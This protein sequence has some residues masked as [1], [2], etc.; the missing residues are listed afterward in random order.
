MASADLAG[1]YQH[2]RIHT[3]EQEN[4][5]TPDEKCED[6]LLWTMLGFGFDSGPLTFGRLA[7]ALG[8]MLQGMSSDCE[9]RLQI[10][11]DDPRW[12]LAGIPKRRRYLL[13]QQLM[14]LCALGCQ[15]SW[16]KGTRGTICSWIGAT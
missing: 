4:A 10:Y 15:I 5:L 6:F 2:F 13:A 9:M 16:Q 8:S 1:A 12:T 7:A 3:N 11:L 14:T